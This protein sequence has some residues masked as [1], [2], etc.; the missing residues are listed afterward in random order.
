MLESLKGTYVNDKTDSVEEGSYIW[1]NTILCTLLDRRNLPDYF[2]FFLHKVKTTQITTLMNTWTHPRT[3]MT[4][5]LTYKWTAHIWKTTKQTTTTNK[6]IATLVGKKNSHQN[7]KQTTINTNACHNWSAYRNDLP[8]P[9]CQQSNY[10]PS[11]RQGTPNRQQITDADAY[12]TESREK[13]ETLNRKGLPNTK[14]YNKSKLK[15]IDITSTT[16]MIITTKYLSDGGYHPRLSM[17]A[18]KCPTQHGNN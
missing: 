4:T 14:G 6:N 12:Q 10:T 15:L 16:P 9:K 8:N 2:N 13:Q 17:V 5:P 18:H 7:E 11:N 1:N 3:Q